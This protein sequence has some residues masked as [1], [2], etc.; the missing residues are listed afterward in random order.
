MSLR[1]SRAVQNFRLPQTSRWTANFSMDFCTTQLL[2]DA[3]S[4]TWNHFFFWTNTHTRTSNTSKNQNKHT[5][6]KNIGQ[7]NV[8]LGR[9]SSGGLLRVGCRSYI[10]SG[11]E[12][13][14]TWKSCVYSLLHGGVRVHQEERA[15][16][17]LVEMNSGQP[18][19][20]DHVKIYWLIYPH[21]RHSI[22]LD[23]RIFGNSFLFTWIRGFISIQTY[24]LCQ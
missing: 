2:I 1:C 20:C 13:A 10:T 12:L 9:E 11:R 16:G 15:A 3:G 18:R 5:Q 4:T 14:Q 6:K 22:L 8:Y 17:S 19:V 24:F 7:G 23:S 21:W